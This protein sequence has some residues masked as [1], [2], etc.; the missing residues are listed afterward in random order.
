[1]AV[2]PD[3]KF[4]TAAK[5]ALI[6]GGMTVTDLAKKLKRPRQTVSAVISGSERFPKL[7]K[8]VAKALKISIP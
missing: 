8:Q 1:M 4:S 5:V 6:V 7:R 2:R 3:N